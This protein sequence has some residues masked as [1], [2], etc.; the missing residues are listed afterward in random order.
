MHKPYRITFTG[1]D[2]GCSVED[3]LALI[4]EEPRLE[5]AFL[6]SEKRQGTGRYPP[7]A[8][9]KETAE[10]IEYR[11]G[12]GRVALHICGRAR[13]DYLDGKPIN[14]DLGSL[15]RFYRVQLNGPLSADQAPQLRRI[16]GE[17]NA[18]SVITQYDHNP[19]LHERIRCPGHQVLF[20]ASGGRGI[21]RA[22]WPKHLGDW[23]CG[24]AGGLG[25]HNLPQQLP[26]IAEAAKGYR[27]WIDMEGNL[28]D[29]QDRFS[30]ERARQALTAIRLTET[31]HSSESE[32]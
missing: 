17:S 20:D 6:Y 26:R 11:V 1:A 8:W 16:L 23:T 10:R 31:Q 30:I 9:I 14:L 2:L 15:W 13:S 25:P 29:E 3:L 12:S 7:A 4:S 22:E 18:Y 28:R 32:E 5:L 27:Y 21:E 24:Y 19:E